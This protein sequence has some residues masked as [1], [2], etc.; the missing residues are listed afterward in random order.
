MK[1]FWIE[2]SSNEIFKSQRQHVPEHYSITTTTITKRTFSYRKMFV[3]ENSQHNLD[4]PWWRQALPNKVDLEDHVYTTS[5]RIINHP[6]HN[7]SNILACMDWSNHLYQHRLPYTQNTHKKKI[8][9]NDACPMGVSISP[10]LQ[11][12]FLLT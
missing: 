1:S 3:S 4:V 7:L 6:Q 12:S 10:L 11:S 9:E 8:I 5:K 2:T